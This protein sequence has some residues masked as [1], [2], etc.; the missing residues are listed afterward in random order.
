MDIEILEFNRDKFITECKIASHALKEFSWDNNKWSSSLLFYE[1][2]LNQKKR[3]NKK[4]LSREFIDI[5]KSV[6]WHECLDNPAKGGNY[7]ISLRLIESALIT[8][9]EKANIC[10]LTYKVIEYAQTLAFKRYTNHNASK[11][12]NN[13]LKIVRLLVSE[14]IISPNLRFSGCYF[15]EYY[16]YVTTGKNEHK[17][18]NEHTLFFLCNLFSK[19]LTNPRDIF[20]TSIFAL[21]MS[22]P[23]RISEVINLRYDCEVLQRSEDG[24]ARYGLR[25]IGAKGYGEDIKWIPSVMQPIVKEAL[26]RLRVLSKNARFVAS[27]LEDIIENRK[28]ER[29]LLNKDL[30]DKIIRL[31]K[32]R[33]KTSLVK[34]N[35]VQNMASL[36]E[37][38]K[39]K[40]F[41][42]IN[43][44]KS[45][46]YSD[47][48]CL[49]NKDQLH[50]IKQTSIF[51]IYM[52]NPTFFRMDFY[53][54]R[55]GEQPNRWGNIFQRHGLSEQQNYHLKTHQIRH[56]INTLAQRGGLSDIDIAK[57]SGRTHV[58]QNR[59]Y[60]HMTDDELFTASVCFMKDEEVSKE[61]VLK[62]NFGESFSY[63]KNI[64]NEIKY[65]QR[66]IGD[67]AM[68]LRDTRLLTALLPHLEE[69]YYNLKKREDKH[70]KKIQ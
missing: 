25:Y 67:D 35:D 4:Y 51:E 19:K 24:V 6:I 59:V 40:G 62:N 33:D 26:R 52:P 47:M 18:P 63:M 5:A 69:I 61:A 57:W 15:K 37:S 12:C 45:F 70:G 1:L 36:L 42:F 41:P 50:A 55:D 58:K 14:K 32:M 64:I 54:N 9:N 39:P 7:I 8:Y 56:L 28:A 49:L 27:I 60:D 20:T 43:G 68:N 13:M 11:Y 16:D 3:T 22:A 53:S 29:T 44:N 17:L 66:N 65:F 48:L 30:G 10:L 23:W 38:K 21:L 2:N 31:Y 46:K 34:M